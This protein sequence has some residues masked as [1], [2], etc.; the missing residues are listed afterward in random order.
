MVLIDSSY[1][2]HYLEGR[3]QSGHKA[4]ETNWEQPPRGRQHTRTEPVE[5]S[6]GQQG[7]WE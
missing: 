3:S 4:P 7:S 6:P 2:I 5:E 1:L